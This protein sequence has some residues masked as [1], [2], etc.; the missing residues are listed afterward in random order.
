M[1]QQIEVL[2]RESDSPLQQSIIAEELGPVMNELRS[3]LAAAKS[4][5]ANDR[6]YGPFL[7]TERAMRQLK[8]KN[9]QALN[10]RL[11]RNTILRVKTAD[12]RNAYPSFQFESDQVLPALRPVLQALLPHVATEWTVLDWLVHPH[13]YLDDDRPIDRLRAG[14][15]EPVVTAAGED[16]STWSA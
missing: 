10:G 8:L 9:R 12:G 5:E 6:L 1:L 11:R 3:R 2:V 15:T 16:G 13:P 7:T 14:D 4:K